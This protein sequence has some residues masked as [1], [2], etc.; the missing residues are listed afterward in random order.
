MTTNKTTVLMTGA[1]ILV[2]RV[3]GLVQLA[4]R[5]M[6]VTT[7]ILPPIPVGP[8]LQPPRA[9]LMSAKHSRL[10]CSGSNLV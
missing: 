1:T 7:L 2:K 9:A 8:K 4:A 3:A 6:T 5:Q 10:L